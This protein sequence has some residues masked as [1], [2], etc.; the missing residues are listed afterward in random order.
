MKVKESDPEHLIAKIRRVFLG[1]GY[2]EMGVVGDEDK[3]ADLSIS[4]SLRVWG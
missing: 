2:L 1:G 4:S 3:F